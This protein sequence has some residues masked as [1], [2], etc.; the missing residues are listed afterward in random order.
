MAKVKTSFSRLL[1]GIVTLSQLRSGGAS[2]KETQQKFNDL[3]TPPGPFP[4]STS[5]RSAKVLT[6][7]SAKAPSPVVSP[8]KLKTSSAKLK[9]RG[10][11]ILNG[12][13]RG[14]SLLRDDKKFSQRLGGG[15]R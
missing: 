7:P 11:R 13:G 5:P 15:A 9:K 1:R 2:V 14:G 12:G 3:F 4:S 8:A 6:S 10:A